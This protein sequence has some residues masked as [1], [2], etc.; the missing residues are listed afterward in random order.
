MLNISPLHGGVTCFT[1][2]FSRDDLTKISP[3]QTSSS[4]LGSTLGAA[5]G[6][7]DASEYQGFRTA[8]MAAMAGG[9][10]RWRYGAPNMDSPNIREKLKQV[11]WR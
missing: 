7:S 3:G 10:T 2:R 4:S 1:L 6:L 5:S 11:L 8:A 9:G